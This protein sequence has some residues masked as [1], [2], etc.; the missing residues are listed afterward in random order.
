[1]RR[2]LADFGNFINFAKVFSQM[3]VMYPTTAMPRCCFI[4]RTA[5]P[6]M[7]PAFR[8]L[9]S[10]ASSSSK[11]ANKGRPP[12]PWISPRVEDDPEVKRR[13]DLLAPIQDLVHLG[14]KRPWSATLET[15]ARPAFTSAFAATHD[16]AASIA[17][18]TAPLI[19]PAEDPLLAQFV[20]L[21]MKHGQKQKARKVV[22]DMLEHIRRLT[23]SEPM[24]LIRQACQRAMPMVD[25][26]R[27]K[28]TGVKAIMVPRALNERQRLRRAILT[29]VDASQRRVG[30]QRGQRI[31][32]EL[33]AVLNGES[34]VIKRKED[35]HRAAVTARSN[36]PGARAGSATR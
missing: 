15:N 5:I 1:M 4:S 21:L 26:R 17:A 7:H 14:G 25:V 6:A 8:R 23:N 18:K 24:P 3:V 33:V 19:P 12:P 29:I 22:S 32:I 20:G 16:H 36:V 10:S 13:Y 9:A 2:L 35:T 28:I 30:T 11:T 27:V 34:E 31:A